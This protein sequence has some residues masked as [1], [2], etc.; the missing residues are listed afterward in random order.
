MEI[1]QKVP[2]FNYLEVSNLG[3]LRTTVR[4]VV[5]MSRAGRNYSRKFKGK[6]LPG[7]I[8][9]SGYK[10]TN[11]TDGTTYKVAPHIAVLEAFIGPR[12]PGFHACHADGNRLNNDIT[13]LRWA[14]PK[15]NAADKVNHGTHS[16]GEKNHNACGL[17]NAQA[18]AIKT[19][20]RKRGTAI[21]LAKQLGGKVTPGIINSI[22]QGVRWKHINPDD[23]S[24]TQEFRD[25]ASRM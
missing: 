24:H 5:Q 2:N 12:P 18:A 11:Y 9:K 15:D 4:I 7:F 16:R 19:L 10:Y 21:R 23:Y 25:L 22:M 17:T 13:N 3:Q 8:S 14:S 1:W 20:P 6:L